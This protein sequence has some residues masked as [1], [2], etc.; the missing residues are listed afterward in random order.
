MSYK[1]ASTVF[2]AA[3]SF[4]GGLLLVCGNCFASCLDIQYVIGNGSLEIS[5]SRKSDKRTTLCALT[6]PCHHR[7]GLGSCRVHCYRTR[8]SGLWCLDHFYQPRSQVY[9]LPCYACG[10]EKSSQEPLTCV[11]SWTALFLFLPRDF[12]V[13]SV[14]SDSAWSVVPRATT[15]MES[16]P[17]VCSFK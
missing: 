9:T 12:G 16:I 17:S 1:H 6:P 13:V 10:S 15:E 2:F 8:D 4:P 5:W 14:F 11:A 3:Q 7:S